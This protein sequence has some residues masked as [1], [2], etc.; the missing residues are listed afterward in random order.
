MQSISNPL[1]PE[2]RPV[3]RGVYFSFA[4]LTSVSYG[5]AYPMHRV[6]RSMAMAEALIGQ[7]YS[8]ILLATLVGMGVA[9]AV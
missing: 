6:A 5:D 8:S 3:S 4:S 1:L 9:G 7:L 2:V